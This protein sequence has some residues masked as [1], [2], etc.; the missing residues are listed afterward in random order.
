MSSSLWEDEIKEIP[1][2]EELEKFVQKKIKYYNEERY[3]NS[4][5][6]TTPL[7]YTKAYLSFLRNGSVK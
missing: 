7:A 4:I 5:G 6:R 3:H 2:F 1:N